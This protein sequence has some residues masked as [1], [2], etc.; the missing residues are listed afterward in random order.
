MVLDLQTV[1]CA[2]FQKKLISIQA[3]PATKSFFNHPC[4]EFTLQTKQFAVY[5]QHPYFLA[6][7]SGATKELFHNPLKQKSAPFKTFSFQEGPFLNFY[8]HRR[9]KV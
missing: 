3:P 2:D 6:D 8:P 9:L 1:D 4:F 5:F 7:F